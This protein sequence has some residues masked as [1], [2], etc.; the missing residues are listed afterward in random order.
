VTVAPPGAPAR[1]GGDRRLGT[2]AADYPGP[3]EPIQE[4]ARAGF[5]PLAQASGW[6]LW[7][8]CGPAPHT[9]G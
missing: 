3:I 8:S 5:R 2:V 7:A 1:G 9:T 4:P 6:D